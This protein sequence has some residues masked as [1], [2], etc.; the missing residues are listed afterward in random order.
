MVENKAILNR[1]EEIIKAH[2][3]MPRWVA[4]QMLEIE[5]LTGVQY[6]DWIDRIVE[7]YGDKS[8]F[9]ILSQ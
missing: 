3:E 8:I 1:A 6:G 2:P 9:E 7:V 4:E 5:E